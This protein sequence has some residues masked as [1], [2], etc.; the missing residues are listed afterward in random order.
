MHD[1]LDPSGHAAHTMPGSDPHFSGA[2]KQTHDA[3]PPNRW[4]FLGIISSGLFL[5]SAD[6]SILYT[7][8]PTLNSELGMTQT[9]SLWV[10]NAYSLVLAG[11]LLG[12]GT[13]GDKIGHRRMFVVG[14]WLFALTSLIAAYAPNAVLLIAARALLGVGAATTLP[15]TL[16][17]L[18][19][20]FRDTRERNIAIS[21]W[22]SVAAL[23]AAAGPVLGGLM[24]EHFFWGSVFLVNVPV[25][26][27]AIAA[28]HRFAPPNLPNPQR[29]WDLLSSAWAMVAMTGLV[30]CIKALH[31]PAQLP[32]AVALMAVGSALFTLRQRKL[33]E[34][35]LT[36]DIFRSRLFSAGFLTATGLITLITGVILVTTQRFQL[37]QGFGPM[38]AG[39]VTG[40]AALAA[41]PFSFL[42]GF[43]LHK[44]GYRTIISGGFALMTLGLC[45]AWV[46]PSEPR[47]PFL[48]TLVVF[49]VGSG[50]A[51]SVA[52][53]A[54]VTSAPR[55]RAGM[56]SA[57]ESVAYEFGALVSVAVFGTLLS[58][59]YTR[60]SGLGD[61][62]TDTLDPTAFDTAFY[63]IIGFAT[64]LS[65]AL[66]VITAVLLRGNPKEGDFDHEE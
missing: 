5:L 65:A 60:A 34:P 59:L 17:L 20:T 6:N 26:I 39:M 47:W 43:V 27:V 41:F 40:V 12:T 63:Q 2:R 13:L 8:L 10:L 14:L 53:T 52:S 56:A 45:A 49:G 33:A 46:V 62:R 25:A 28:T 61:L 54:I 7:A 57:L 50:L 3:K 15:A 48:L 11:L 16:A 32:I 23:G 38:Q 58:V 64:V 9:Q 19:Q 55:A 42:G 51:T 66:T 1:P 37:T 4:L 36:I 18:R 35:L 29:H 21:V 30:L 31:H 44:L 24:L 22:G